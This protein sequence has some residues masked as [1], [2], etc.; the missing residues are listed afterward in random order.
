[1]A[2]IPRWLTIICVVA[3]LAAC[4]SSTTAPTS[5]A[6][7][8]A[9][10]DVL[11]QVIGPNGTRGFSLKDLQALP[12]TTIT[13]EGKSEDGPA[14]LEVLKAAGITDFK[15]VTISGSGS[16]TLSKEQVTAEVIF[17]FTNRGTVKF[18]ATHIDKATWPKDIT[19]IEVK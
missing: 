6:A 3:L 18:A 9:G 11:L 14:V 12:T 7:A 15:E 5:P 10:A 4:S 17:D 13:V 19:R 8:P 1:M 2:S 16:V